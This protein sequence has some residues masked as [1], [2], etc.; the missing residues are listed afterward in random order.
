MSRKLEQPSPA[1][2]PGHSALTVK[3]IGVPSRMSCT[4]KSPWLQGR[5]LKTTGIVYTPYG[6][7]LTGTQRK[8]PHL[9]GQAV[10]SPQQDMGQ[11]VQA[12]HLARA[13]AR[14]RPGGVCEN[15]IP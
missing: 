6:R 3:Y 5:S 10:F 11:G 9:G 12:C 4:G 14:E 15:G 7:R 8:E 13:E 1:L 2:P